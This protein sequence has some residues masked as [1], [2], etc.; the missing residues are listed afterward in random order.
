MSKNT[1]WSIDDLKKKGLVQTEN[2]NYVPVKSLSPTGKVQKIEPSVTTFQQ[3]EIERVGN[4]KIQNATKIEENGVKFDSLLEKYMYY[5]LRGAQ[6]DFQFQKIFILQP[7]FKYRT[8]NIRAIYKVVDFYIESKSILIDTKG[9]AN[10]LSPMKHKM[11]KYALINDY[12][13]QPEIFMPKNRKE[14]DLLLNKLLYEI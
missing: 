9:Y 13:I 8:K 7:K 10:D 6:I 12:G 4:R 1:R 5:L 2:G 14:C 3:A 11:L